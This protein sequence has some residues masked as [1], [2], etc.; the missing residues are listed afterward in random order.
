MFDICSYKNQKVYLVVMYCDTFNK[1]GNAID[2]IEGIYTTRLA[3]IKR[4][5]RLN[6]EFRYKWGYHIAILEMPVKGGKSLCKSL[7]LSREY[8]STRSS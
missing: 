2:R 3:A 4:R 6:A 8:V 7:K 5:C 1:D